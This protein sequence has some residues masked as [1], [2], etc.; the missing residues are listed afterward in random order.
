MTHLRDVNT[1][2]VARGYDAFSAMDLPT[3][4]EVL[5]PD[6]VWIVGG[7]NKLSATYHGR[8][9]T[10]DYF[11]KLLSATAGAFRISVLTVTE[12]V[13]DTVLVSA[14]LTAA[15]NGRTFDEEVVQELRLRNRQVVSCRTFLQNG[16]LFDELIGSA[17]IVLPTQ[18]GRQS[19][20]V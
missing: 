4:T 20:T 2:I 1:E 3:L 14:H 8:D 10:L 12:V 9:A 13:P 6:C 7:R 5:S 19:S 11:G 17:Q 18:S 15:G 16:H